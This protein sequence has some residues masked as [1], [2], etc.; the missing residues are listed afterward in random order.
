MLPSESYSVHISQKVK[1][2]LYLAE[3]FHLRIG[4]GP[5]SL[6]GENTCLLTASRY[7]GQKA[8]LQ[9][10]PIVWHQRLYDCHNYSVHQRMNESEWDMTDSV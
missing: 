8:Q 3:K 7:D 6:S 10:G 4:V 1:E 9:H 5:P 2:G